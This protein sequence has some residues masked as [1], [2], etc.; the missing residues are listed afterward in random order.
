MHPEDWAA[1]A[2]WEYIMTLERRTTNGERRT[3]GHPAAFTLIEVLVAM[4]VLAVM[5]LMVANIFQSSSAAWNIGT[6]K[7]DMNTAARAALDFMARELQSAVAGPVEKSGSGEAQYLTFHQKDINYLCFL[8]LTD[9]PGPDKDGKIHRA[10]QGVY[11]WNDNQCLKYTHETD[12]LDCYTKEDWY[13]PYP[14]GFN[15]Y[16]VI[17]NVLDLRFYVYTN[18]TDLADGKYIL[19]CPAIL[20][21]L[22]LC[23]DIALELLSDDDMQKY[24]A[25]SQDQAFKAR[26]AKL[27]S[28]R[29]YFPNRVGYQAR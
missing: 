24:N 7:S 23:V 11:F 18:E 25:M 13:L 27:Y 8:A 20:N 3:G 29:V 2:S 9:M 22:P 14:S 5:V 4:T 1:L 15:N 16:D 17:T 10:L 19:S 28:T 12:S 6:Q 26:N 21:E